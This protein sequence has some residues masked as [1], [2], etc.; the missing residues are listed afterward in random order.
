VVADIGGLQFLKSWFSLD[1]PPV[2]QGADA[3]KEEADA[4]G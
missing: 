1:E 3:A 2:G 4:T